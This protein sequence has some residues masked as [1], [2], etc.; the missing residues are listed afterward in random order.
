MDQNTEI[1]HEAEMF[2]DSIRFDRNSVEPGVDIV[3]QDAESN[4]VL[5]LGYANREALERTIASGQIW[6][7]SRSRQV[8]WHKGATSG[9]RLE[10]VSIF[11]NCN[12]DSLLI[13]VRRLGQDGGVCHTADANGKRRPSCFFR[14][15]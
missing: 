4:E 6:L 7:W 14:Q 9:D 11:V 3:I 2:I 1:S 12:W 15:L 8:L 13:K 10:V 5:M